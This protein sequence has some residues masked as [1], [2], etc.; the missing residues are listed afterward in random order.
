MST[1]TIA[2]DPVLGVWL[3]K[4]QGGRLSSASGESHDG[5]QRDRTVLG[6]AGENACSDTEQ[7][8]L[9]GSYGHPPWLVEVHAFLEENVTAMSTLEAN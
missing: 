6:E 4:D 9:V 2:E 7:V 1:D 5:Y 3:Y 8:A